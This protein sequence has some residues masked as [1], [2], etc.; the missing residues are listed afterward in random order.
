MSRANDQNFHLPIRGF[1]DHLEGKEGQIL[2]G[3]F[4]SI[5]E[6]GIGATTIRAI[7]A[8]A[9]VNPGI[10]HY[11]FKSK[12]HLLRRLLEICYQNVIANIEAL[13][14]TDLSPIEKIE[15]LFELGISL[16][17]PRKD[18]WIVLASFWA[19]SMTADRDMLRLHRKLNR[20]LQAALI[21][22]IAEATADF[23]SGMSKNIAL[24][25]LGAVR[26]LAFHYVLDPKQF[27]PERPV[28][29]LQEMIREALWPKNMDLYQGASQ[30]SVG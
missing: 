14:T 12:D 20:R 17:G 27:D 16:F 6:I 29:L 4:Q 28:Y 22:I 3:A 1:Q 10:I 8:K 9:G 25:M 26:G 19:H 5:S 24:L 11:Y 18:E 7:A 23:G 13:S 2:L 15:S 21:N 30:K